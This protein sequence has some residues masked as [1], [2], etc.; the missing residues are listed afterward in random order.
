MR[1]HLYKAI[2]KSRDIWIFGNLI[3]EEDKA[4]IN[5]ESPLP[6]SEEDEEGRFWLRAEEI[7][8]ETICEFTGVYDKNK[9]KIFENDVILTKTYYSHGLGKK[10]PPPKKVRAYVYL[11]IDPN[12]NSH[13]YIDCYDKLKNYNSARYGEFTGCVVLGNRFDKNIDEI[14][15]RPLFYYNPPKRPFNFNI[16]KVGEKQEDG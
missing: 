11:L 4:Y 14:L 15:K 12:R 5:Y 8:P 6:P 2:S 1:E 7:I 16:E 3:V 13:W 9:Q 10:K